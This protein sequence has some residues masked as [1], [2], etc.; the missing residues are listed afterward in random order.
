MIRRAFVLL[1]VLLAAGAA[2][3]LVLEKTM[4]DWYARERYPLRYAFI[5]RGHAQ[6]YH[7]DPALLAAVIYTESKFDAHSV[8]SAGA[9]L[10]HRD[11]AGLA[12]MLGD[13]EA[14][15]AHLRR[16]KGGRAHLL[17][18]QLGMGVDVA[19]QLHELRHV[20]VN[21]VR[22]GRGSSSRGSGGHRGGGKP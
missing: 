10:H 13:V 6:H 16:Q 14:E 21:G 12:D 22:Q 2:A 7:L 17:H 5:V 11:D 15:L 20:G 18:R 9:V 8:S 3:I 4:P 1:V 19:V